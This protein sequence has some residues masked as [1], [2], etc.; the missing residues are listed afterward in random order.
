[1]RTTAAI[2]AALVALAAAGS[3]A[4]QQ[5]PIRIGL[6]TGLTG[7]AALAA[8]WER[9]G[10]AIAQEEIN[11]SGG[12]LGRKV[13]IV[14]VDN[15]CN[16]TEGANTARRLVQEKVAAIAGGHCSS[17]TLAMMPIIKDA[18]IPMVTGVSSS[19]RIAELSGANGNEFMFRI[20]P[21]DAQMASA[22]TEYLGVKKPFRNVAIIA[23]DSD[24]GRGGAAAFTP[25]A[26]KAGMKI[27]ST[28]YPPQMTPDFTSLLTRVGQRRP[29][30]IAIF[31][32][33][34][35]QLNLLRT[36]M[37]LGIRIPYTGRAE[38]AGQNLDLIRQGGMEGSISAWTYSPDVDTPV[39]KAFAQ[40]FAVR[41]KTRATLQAWAGYD[42]LR[43]L[44]QAIREAKSDDPVKIRDALAK[45]KFTNA[46]GK[47]TAFD[48]NNQGGKV[49]VI[50]AVKDNRVVILDLW[51][52]K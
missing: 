52:V 46:L 51:D 4:A 26:E 40:K 2:A 6:S 1:M 36:A 10:T 12:L 37:Q 31:M 35:D 16:P 9:W 14:A 17:A 45:V 28:D 21:D 23:E 22:L 27:V 20:N 11:E 39:N 3:A 24:F 33:G 5:P 41:H 13:E 47:V 19:P 50:Q 25:L 32:L 7:P 34:A 15:R 48:K 18:K 8:E 42:Q 38:L 30:A 43:V 49:V 44:A 29:D